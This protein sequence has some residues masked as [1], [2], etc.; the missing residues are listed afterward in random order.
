MIPALRDWCEERYLRL[1]EC[2]LRWGVPKDSTSA[3]TISTCLEEIEQCHIEND[4]RP[5]F[6]NMLGERYV[7]YFSTSKLERC[8]LCSKRAFCKMIFVLSLQIWLGTKRV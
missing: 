6:I 3:A 8:E 2:D 4:N 5:F 1:I 7:L